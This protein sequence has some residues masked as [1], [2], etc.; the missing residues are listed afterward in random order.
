MLRSQSIRFRDCLVKAVVTHRQQRENVPS[1]DEITRIYSITTRGDPLRKLIGDVC[2]WKGKACVTD[3]AH[4]EFQCELNAGLLQ[5]IAEMQEYIN[6]VQRII[7]FSTSKT[8]LPNSVTSKKHTGS[9]RFQ[10]GMKELIEIGT[11]RPFQID[12]GD[13]VF[14]MIPAAGFR[15]V[16]I[17]ALS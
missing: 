2:I 16:R 5:G 1:S 12:A 14:K 13:T 10:L 6:Q 7:N 9:L 4:V 11:P 17:T 8:P 3:V 15:L